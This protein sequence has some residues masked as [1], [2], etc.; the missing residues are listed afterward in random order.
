M[1]EDQD[2]LTR[3]LGKLCIKKWMVED[4]SKL[5]L[6]SPIDPT[7]WSFVLL[8]SEKLEESTIP[9]LF[10]NQVSPTTNLLMSM[11]ENHKLR[12]TY[13]FERAVSRTQ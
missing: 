2:H 8:L 10:G 12:S 4:E 11:L 1:S 13:D 5:S 6:D 7:V 9:N 3:E